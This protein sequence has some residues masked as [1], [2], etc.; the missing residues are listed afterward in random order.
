MT[1]PSRLAAGTILLF[2]SAIA[3]GNFP[4]WEEGAVTCAAARA[5][6]TGAGSSARPVTMSSANTPRATITVG[7]RFISVPHFHE[8]LQPHRGS[9]A[10]VEPP[11][12][13]RAAA[14]ERRGA[15]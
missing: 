11:G 1:S 2:H 10:I 3:A 5:V 7:R 14:L 9:A 8:E 15:S 4:A 6:R 12:A 13:R